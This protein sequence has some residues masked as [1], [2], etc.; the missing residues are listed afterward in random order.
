MNVVFA[1]LGKL[2]LAA[3]L[4]GAIGLERE[5]KHRSAGL[6][7]NVFICVGAAL[8]TMLSDQLAAIHGG[9]HTRIAAQIIPGIG[10][11]GAG[12]ILHSRDNLVTGL[13]TAATIFVVA[14]TGMSVGGGRF[15][16][17]IF[18]TALIL[19]VLLVLGLIERSF[20]LKLLIHQ[21]EV[22][23]Q[24]ADE[25]VRQVNGLLEPVHAMMSNLQLAPTPVHVRVRFECEGTRNKQA[26]ILQALRESGAFHSVTSLGPVR[27]E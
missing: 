4:G 22:S 23:G 2:L 6:R 17:A 15:A 5:A 18:T 24:N 11:I 3:V 19:A 13:T 21:Y 8:F 9:D 10:F 1:D 20:N 26:Q 16:L 12:T 25:L 14:A 7:T 27:I